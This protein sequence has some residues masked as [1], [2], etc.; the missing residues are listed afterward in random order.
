VMITAY[1]T[2]NSAV[3]A[4][5]K[6]A[7]DY[8]PKPFTPEQLRILTRRAVEYKRLKEESLRLKNEK[9]RIEKGFI[10]FVSHE[11]RSPLV[12]IRQFMES[13]KMI[14]ADRFDESI[15]EIVDKCERRLKGLEDLVEHWLDINRIEQGTFAQKKDSLSLASVIARSVEEMLPLCQKNS[16][17]LITSIPDDLLKVEGD[18]E[19]LVRVLTNLIGNATKYTPEGGTI[20]VSARNDGPYVDISVSDTGKGIPSDKLPFIFEAFYR[21]KG[22]D[23]IYRGSGL[24]LTYCKK[25]VETHGGQISAFS[26][27]GEGTTVRI[28]VP[29]HIKV[30]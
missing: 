13:M 4:I 11:M 24:G 26:K 7:Y 23:E 5:K 20:T 30:I 9:E 10:T 28:R 8:L 18:E 16:L 15:L 12:V 6:G 14:A 17:S 1:A 2:I 3:D 29:G 25:I 22:K 27:E 19:S 21:V